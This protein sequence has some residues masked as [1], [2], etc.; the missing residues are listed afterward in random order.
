MSL[1]PLTPGPLT[2]GTEE[3]V[4]AR[5]C[6]FKLENCFQKMAAVSC[7]TIVATN[8]C[9][10]PVKVQDLSILPQAGAKT[11]ITQSTSCKLQGG[12]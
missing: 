3:W 1:Q 8:H 10:A 4:S 2:P 12:G 5:G 6:W 11:V 9:F 7:R